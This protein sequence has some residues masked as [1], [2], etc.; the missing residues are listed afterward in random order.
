MP[1][2]AESGKIGINRHEFMNRQNRQLNG[3]RYMPIYNA[4][5]CRF[6]PIYADLCRFMQ[7]FADFDDLGYHRVLESGRVAR[8]ARP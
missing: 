6:M 3:H 7:I 2:N 8:S 5:L 4:D 1:I